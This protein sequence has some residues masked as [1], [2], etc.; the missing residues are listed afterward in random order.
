MQ[1]VGQG[2]ELFLNYCLVVNFKMN[3]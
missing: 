2:F 1:G 3:Y